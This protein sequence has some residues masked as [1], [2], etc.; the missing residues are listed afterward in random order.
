L[1]FGLSE[2]L[3]SIHEYYA[4]TDTVSKVVFK[5]SKDRKLDCADDSPATELKLKKDHNAG[6]NQMI[7]HVTQLSD[8]TITTVK[9]VNQ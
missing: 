5:T 7:T 9:F 8:G 4:G 2:A 3:T 1:T 6:A